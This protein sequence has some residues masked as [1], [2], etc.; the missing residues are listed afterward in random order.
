[1]TAPLQTILDT[2]VDNL[3]SGVAFHKHQETNPR[4]P[5]AIV[6][7][8]QPCGEALAEILAESIG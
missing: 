4:K 1:L 3:R 6:R 8:R 5:G 7:A 2:P